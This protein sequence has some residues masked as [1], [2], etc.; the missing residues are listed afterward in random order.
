MM[1]L[2]VYINEYINFKWVYIFE[3][4]FNHQQRI[5]YFREN[6][7]NIDHRE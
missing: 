5:W 1:I 6:L 4:N 2:Y 7:Q 3:C